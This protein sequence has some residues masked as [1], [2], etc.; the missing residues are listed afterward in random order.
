[1]TAIFVLN[2]KVTYRDVALRGGAV[3]RGLALFYLVC[4][5]GAAANIGVAS[6]LLADDI[7]GWGLAGAAGALMTVV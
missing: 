2:N 1:M 5:L 3:W 6:L 4:G 7:L